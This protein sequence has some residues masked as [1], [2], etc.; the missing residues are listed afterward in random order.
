MKKKTNKEKKLVNEMGAHHASEEEEANCPLCGGKEEGSGYGPGGPSPDDMDNAQLKKLW[1]ETGDEKYAEELESRGINVR[2]SYGELEYDQGPNDLPQWANAALGRDIGL[3]GM[4]AHSARFEG[5]KMKIKKSDLRQL[6]SE[7]L[8]SYPY[9]ESSVVSEEPEAE[10]PAGGENSVVAK[11][12]AKIQ[13]THGK[14]MAA[15][16]K[17]RTQKKEFALAMLNYLEMTPADMTATT[18]DATM[19]QKQDA[20]QGVK[21]GQDASLGGALEEKK[22]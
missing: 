14:L 19:Q 16:L 1:N 2:G 7:E 6:I 22:K 8:E 4:E 5:K 13:Q 12:V 20:K 9:G 11:M 15:N 3:G 10:A 18:R 17:T 21:P